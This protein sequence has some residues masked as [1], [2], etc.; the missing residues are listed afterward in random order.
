MDRNMKQCVICQKELVPAKKES[1]ARF[2][3]KKTCANYACRQL[4]KKKNKLGFNNVNFLRKEV[5]K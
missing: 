5:N 3:K 2:E 4:Y 1:K